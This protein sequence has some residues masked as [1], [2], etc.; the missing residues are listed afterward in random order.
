MIIKGASRAVKK[1]RLVL[2]AVAIFLKGRIAAFREYYTYNYIMI[3]K[4]NWLWVGFRHRVGSNV[5]ELFTSGEGGNSFYFD[6]GQF[7]LFFQ[8]LKA[9]TT[10]YCDDGRDPGL[11]FLF[12]LK[13]GDD[14]QEFDF[15]FR[16]GKRGDIVIGF[17]S[18][19]FSTSKKMLLD[20]IA[21]YELMFGDRNPL[22]RSGI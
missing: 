6:K 4:S 21:K 10:A 12:K 19:S 1:T 2:C 22:T 5:F 3:L 7:D 17:E 8:N 16:E 14:K 18:T 9:I 11:I 15:R 13:E 20:A